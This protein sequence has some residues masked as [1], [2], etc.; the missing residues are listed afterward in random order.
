MTIGAGIFLAAVGAILTFAVNATVA[1]LNIHAIG[2]ILMLAG[3]IGIAIELA[4]F[5]PRRRVFRT[6]GYTNGYAAPAR[7][8]VRTVHAGAVHAGS[9][10]AG[11][12]ATPAVGLPVTAT[13][14]V[15]TPVVGGVPVAPQAVVPPQV[16]HETRY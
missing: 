4:V 16:V 2:V 14:V 7:E 6:T 12:V 13:P 1:G 9:V 8:S 15:A 3:V 10:H 11:T 5:A